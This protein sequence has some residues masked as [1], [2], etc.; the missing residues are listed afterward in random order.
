MC[1]IAGIFNVDAGQPVPERILRRMT[2]ALSHRGPDGDGFHIEPGIGLGHRRLAIID[3]AT[4]DQPMFNEDGSVAIVFNGEIYNHLSLRPELERRGHVFRSRS[5]TEAI[6]H[7]WESWGPGCLKYLSGMFAFALWDR[8]KGYLFLA[9][10]RLGKKPLYYARTVDGSLVFG[11]ELGAL[12]AHPGISRRISPTAIDDYFAFGYVPDPDC[13]FEGIAKLPAAHYLVV[14]RNTTSLPKPECY[15]SP[16]PDPRPQNETEAIVELRRRLRNCVEARLIADVPLGAFLSGGVDSSA[17]VATMA[18]LREEP[19]ETFTISFDGDADETQFA[20]AMAERYGTIHH[21]ENGGSIDYIGAAREQAAIFG[22]PFAD[23]S[24]VPTHRVSCMTRRHVT[25]ALSGDG[26][27]ELFAGYRR[28]RWHRITE[29]VRAYFPAPL[30]RT[31]FAELARIYPKLDHAPQWLRAKTTLTEISLDAAL[32]YYRTLCKLHDDA[33]RDL[34][35]PE[36]RG[37]VAGYEPS[38]R[39]ATL[40][41][42]SATADP[43]LQAQYV[44]LKSYLVGDILTKVDRAS[45]AASLEARAPLLDHE[46]VEWAMTLPTSLTLRRG[47]GKYLLKRAL[48]GQV[49]NENLYRR[50]QGFAMSLAECFRGAA[51]LQV[52][53]RLLSA[54]MLDSGL[55]D[56]D[57]LARLIDVHAARGADH[58]AAIWALLVFEGFL[59]VHEGEVARP[60]SWRKTPLEARP[61]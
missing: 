21:S 59:A 24:S 23:S 61:K 26:G 52:R 5:D 58:S 10:D 37:A 15:W 14:G 53:D 40:M 30:R 18:T 11:S 33:R 7:A 36:L 13:I 55:F 38:R 32:G 16:R 35:A 28:Y 57:A 19:T 31:I 34:F 39:I 47:E 44:D 1:G 12:L 8:N 3:L 49:P 54:R 51:A 29:A 56:A 45:M 48:E 27:D 22:E 2:A 42:E 50:K 20:Q 60:P 41:Q 9:R 43:L 46:L 17:I 25:V 6:I 4:G